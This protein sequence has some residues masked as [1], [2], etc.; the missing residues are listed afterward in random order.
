MKKNLKLFFSFL[1]V[2]SVIGFYGYISVY[3][4]ND[5]DT[6]ESE[7][8]S[9]N[10][11]S[12]PTMKYS[13]VSPVLL[14]AADTIILP[15]NPG[16]PNN[17]LSAG[18]PGALFNLI[19]GSRD[20][21]VTKLRTASNATAGGPISFEVYI[22]D[23]NALGG[24]VASG[25]GSS[26]AGWT[27]ID[28]A[29]GVQG[30]TSSGISE[31]IALGPILVGAGDTVGVCLRYTVGGVRYFGTGSPPLENYNDTNIRLITGDG[32]SAPFTPTGSFFSSRALTGEIRYVVST[33]TGITNLNIIPEGF[34]LGQN[35]PNPFNP[36]T[37]ILFSIPEKNNVTLK[38]FDSR[39]REVAQL[40]NDEYSAGTYAVKWNAEGF[41]SGVYFYKITTGNF[42]QTKKLL[43]VK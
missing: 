11:Q 12:F 17:G 29:T 34:M 35:Y 9:G 28:T 5:A 4:L 19:G 14:S 3:I 8:T 18:T 38:V 22:R 37:N 43:L 41:A 31:P 42:T 7:K 1:L 6:Q 23:G 16:P 15:A 21:Y 2:L 39:G 26:P 27:L 13:P 32:R 24:P 30:P 20:V 25:P 33:T 10:I 40:V 36:S